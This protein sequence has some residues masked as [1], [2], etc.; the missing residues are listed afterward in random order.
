M[1]KNTISRIKRNHGLEHASIHVLSETNADFSAQGN[2]NHNGFYLNIYGNVTDADV[3]NAVRTAHK[4]MKEGEHHLAVHPNCGTVLLTTATMATLAG[5]AALSVEKRR[6]EYRNKLSFLLNGLPT[7][8]LA[9]ALTII[10][11]KPLGLYLQENYTV[12]GNLR[13]LEIESI[14]RI[15]PGLIAVFF[16]R[17]LGNAGSIPTHSFFVKTVG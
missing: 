5:Q 12:D 7:A 6:F 10:A 16:Q 15:R 11:A 9:T 13:D 3:E 14:E 17:L 2:S 1:L 4:R 8:I